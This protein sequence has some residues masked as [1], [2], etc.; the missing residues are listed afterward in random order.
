MLC[1]KYLNN[2]IIY[3]KRKRDY[4]ASDLCQGRSSWMHCIVEF[5]LR[6]THTVLS[7][8]IALQSLHKILKNVEGHPEI[9]S[10]QTTVHS[11]YTAKNNNHRLLFQYILFSDF[12]T[13]L[14]FIKIIEVSLIFNISITEREDQLCVCFKE[15]ETV[16]QAP[17]CWYS[18]VQVLSVL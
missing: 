3:Q 17:D 8:Y 12:Q 13:S 4:I 2:K 9:P 6:Y 1:K 14:F 10:I 18:I 5:T 15:T 7:L 11:V 16:L